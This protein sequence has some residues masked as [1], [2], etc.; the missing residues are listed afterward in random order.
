MRTIATRFVTR[1]RRAPGSNAEHSVLFHGGM[2]IDEAWNHHPDAPS[3]FGNHH[4]PACHGCA[5]RFDETLEEAT[6]AY[7]LT[8][9]TFLADLNALGR[10]Q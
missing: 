4:L 6:G 1:I 8:L 10:E 2:T 7:G 5:V 3:V 9:E